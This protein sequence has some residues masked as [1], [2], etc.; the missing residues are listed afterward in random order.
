MKPLKIERI[1][2]FAGHRGA[3]YALCQ[4]QESHVFYSAGSDG[5]VVQW[6]LQKP[7]IGKVVAQITGSIYAMVYD[8]NAGILWVGQNFEG[9]HG[10]LVADQTRVFSIQLPQ[11]AIYSLAILDGHVWVGHQDGL[12]TVIDQQAQAIKKRIKSG[13][14]NIRCFCQLPNSEMAV[15]SSDGYIR[16]FKADFS[17]KKAWL[18][19]SNSVFSIIQQDE[20]IISVGRDAHIRKWNLKGEG[21]GAGVPAH[22]YTINSVVK[23]PDGQ[24]LATGSMDKTIKIWDPASLKL[25]KV[26][27]FAR[28]GGHKNSI[29]RLIWSTYQDFLVSGSDDKNISVWKID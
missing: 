24:Y 14:H 10:I 7:D 13:E 6:D 23:S 1:D 28:Y 22:I 5:W 21:I 20:Y 12:I 4:G 9:V 19:H 2:T 3:V 29:N 8:E 16:I 25:L 11:L 17:L 27:D 18:A 15:G 26:L